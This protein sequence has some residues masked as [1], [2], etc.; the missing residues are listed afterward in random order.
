MPAASRPYM[1][2]YDMMFQ[3]D[4][5]SLSWAWA[6]DHLSKA[7][8][9]YLSTTRSD[10]RPHVMQVWGDWLD[11]AFYFIHGRRPMKSRYLSINPILTVSIENAFCVVRLAGP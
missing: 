11:R 3:K 2:G 6:V 9:Y 8:N 1:P 10:G 7:S 5:S 4:K